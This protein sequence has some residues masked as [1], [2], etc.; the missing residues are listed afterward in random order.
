M[1][2]GNQ[3]PVEEGEGEEEEVPRER[4]NMQLQWKL[5]RT[6]WYEHVIHGAGLGQ[7][8]WRKCGKGGVGGP[9]LIAVLKGLQAEKQLLM[10]E[11][12]IQEEVEDDDDEDDDDDD[13]EYE[14]DDDVD[15]DDEDDEDDDDDDNDDDDDEDEEEEGKEEEEE[16][17]EPPSNQTHIH[18]SE[19]QT[20]EREISCRNVGMTHL[21]IIHNLEATNLDMAE[22]NLRV[23]SP[24]ALSGLLN[25]DTL[26]LSKNKL[27]DETF[28]QN[29]LSNLTFLKKLSLDGNQLTRIP[30]LPS[31]L[32]VL[33]INHNVLRALTP[34]CFKGFTKLLTL[35][36]DGNLLH[37]ASV[38]PSAFRP[39]ERLI[40]LRL[41]NNRFHSIPRGLPRVLQKLEM[42]ENSIK[43][44]TEEALRRCVH[45]KVLD[46][47]RNRLHEKG[48]A[49][50]AWTRLKSL[51]TLT[52]SHNQ[53]TSVPTNLPRRLRELSLQ[54]NDIS[55]IPAFTFLH[56]R[57]SLQFLQLSHNSLNNEGVGNASFAGTYRSMKELLLNNNHLG[58]VPHCVRQFKSLKVLRLDNNHIRT[59]KRW[60]V[61]H[62]HNAGTTLALVHLENNLLEVEKIHP[63]AFSC[64][65]DARGLILHPQ[66]RHPNV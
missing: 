52:L 25:L 41:G 32:E 53:L 47:S 28:G 14:D 50:H 26:D 62:S 61:C 21:P 8:G 45:L 64:L 16:T 66:K 56:L 5:Q 35:E 11:R 22:N 7:S 48:I 57:S 30:A 58:D 38:A 29:P 49:A 33:K 4:G 55:R 13:D 51:E 20:S 44:V 24:Q 37:E 40:D 65:T 3:R 2:L 12:K 31:S 6:E 34:L 27:D 17:N 15:D 9:V 36:L 18:L 54:H 42:C 43:E 39:L 46:L 19:C 60:G 63:N 23:I 1:L 10:D 59:V